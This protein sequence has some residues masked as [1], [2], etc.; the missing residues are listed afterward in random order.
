ML[1]GSEAILPISE[2]IKASA[3]GD[4]ELNLH[5]KFK[6]LIYPQLHSESLL[7]IRQLFNNGC[8]AILHKTFMN[9]VKDD[10]LVLPGIR[11]K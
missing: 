1:H 7:S 2:R 9:L 3:H 4:L 10:K 11:N 6:G 5:V 8:I